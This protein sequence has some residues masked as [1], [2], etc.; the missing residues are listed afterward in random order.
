MEIF[1][2]K[3]EA[4]TNSASRCLVRQGSQRGY[5]GLPDILQSQSI[6]ESVIYFKK[7]EQI[8]VK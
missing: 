8:S 7:S 5:D 1:L 2:G 6:V 4:V 3:V